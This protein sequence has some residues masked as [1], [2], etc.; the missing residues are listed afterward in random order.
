[1]KTNMN[2]QTIRP[3]L[4]MNQKGP[5]ARLPSVVT[6]P[7]CQDRD[8]KQNK[9]SDCCHRADGVSGFPSMEQLAPVADGPH[10]QPEDD[11]F[12]PGEIQNGQSGENPAEPERGQRYGVSAYDQLFIFD[13]ESCRIV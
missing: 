2:T 8:Q 11:P 5:E 9:T 4:D 7:L 12:A 6:A 13:V 1:M 10:G 3:A